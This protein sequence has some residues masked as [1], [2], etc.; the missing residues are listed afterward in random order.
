MMKPPVKK[1]RARRSAEPRG[2]TSYMIARSKDDA[3]D[4]A[5]CARSWIEELV[6]MDL[7]HEGTHAVGEALQNV[8]AV[9]SFLRRRDRRAR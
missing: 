5:E 9:C 6:R 1:V 4:A 7:G 3:L 2:S 8:R